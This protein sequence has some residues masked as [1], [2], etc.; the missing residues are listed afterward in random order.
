MKTVMLANIIIM[1]VYAICVTLAAI[2]FNDAG[3]L[4]W[5]LMMGVIGFTYKTGSDE[6]RKKGNES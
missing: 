1:S 3:V 2:H 5:Y 6:E 4:W